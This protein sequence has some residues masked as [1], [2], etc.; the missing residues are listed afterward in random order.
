MEP[1]TYPA[2]G[3]R[4]S[5]WRRRTLTWHLFRVHFMTLS[6]TR[7]YCQDRLEFVTDGAELTGVEGGLEKVALADLGLG[8]SGQVLARA[9]DGKAF[10]VKQILD[11][12]DGLNVLAPVQ[13]M[14]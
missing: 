9:G 1:E 6:F 7:K 3:L 14:P 11:L 4:K 12:Q 5:T 13:P 10:P 2:S 8:L